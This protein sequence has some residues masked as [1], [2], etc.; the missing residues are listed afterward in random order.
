[1]RWAPRWQSETGR[2]S[3]HWRFFAILGLVGDML[4]VTLI[5]WGQQDVP[6]G[7]SAILVG[8]M[9]LMTLALAA[10]FVQSERIDRR[11][12]AGFGLGFLGL[13]VL[14]GPEALGLTVRHSLLHEVAILGGAVCFAV[15]AVLL[16]QMPDVHPLTASVGISLC[17]AV[18]AVPL[19]LLCDA[20]W[21]LKP[22]VLSLVGLG[23]LGLFPSALATIIY[24]KLVRAAGPTFA[25][26][27]SYLVPPLAVFLSVV[28]LG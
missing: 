1:V 14:I 2:L 20:P 15:N 12:L 18:I 9:P 5:T 7:R 16:K 8:L 19:A 21:T 3:V 6:S 24:V 26:L 22:S 28:F 10:V 13:V 25:A 27:T 11:H 17:A 4:P 23:L